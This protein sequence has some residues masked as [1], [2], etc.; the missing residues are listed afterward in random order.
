VLLQ[1]EIG[2]SLYGWWLSRRTSTGVTQSVL[3]AEQ[4]VQQSFQ[5]HLS[6]LSAQEPHSLSRDQSVSHPEL[7]NR[8][9]IRVAF[10]QLC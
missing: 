4:Q 10:G 5:Q 1:I 9:P 7:V 8:Q 6:I 2:S 3:L